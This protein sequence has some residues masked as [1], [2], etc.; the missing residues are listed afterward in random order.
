MPCQT[1]EV[2]TSGESGPREAYLPVRGMV[3]ARLPRAARG[4]GSES[5]SFAPG[6]F[7]CGRGI[8]VVRGRRDKLVAVRDERK[9]R[10][11]FARAGQRVDDIW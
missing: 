5:S 1:Q 4:Y 10:V 7:E 11:V 3:V 2:G 6:V 9:S 8:S